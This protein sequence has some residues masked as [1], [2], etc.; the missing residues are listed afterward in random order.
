MGGNAIDD[1]ADEFGDAK[2]EPNDGERIWRPTKLPLLLRAPS[3]IVESSV[4]K[5]AYI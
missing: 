2:I 4:D 3:L 1:D 5:K